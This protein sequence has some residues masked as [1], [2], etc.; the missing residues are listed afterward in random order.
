MRIT[1]V[2][3]T[4]RR[5]LVWLTIVAL[6][7]SL[8]AA[9]ASVTAAAPSKPRVD[10]AVLFAADGL[11]QDLVESYAKQGQMPTM[12]SFLRNG[13]KASGN[14]MLTQAPPNTG[15]G[16]YTMATGAWPGVTGSTN[17]TFHISGQPF[18]NRTAAF[19][20]GVLQA[21]SIAQSAERDGLKVAQVEWAGG[22]NAAIAGPT[23]D[24]R[25]FLSG[26]GVATNFIGA[27][28]EPLFDDVPFISAFGLQFDHPAGYAGQAAFPGA[29]PT[30]VSGWTNVPASYSPAMEMRLRVIDFGTDKYGLNAYIYDSTNNA[31]VDYDRV[32]F[33][34]SKDGAQKVGDLKKGQWADVK[35]KVQGGA[36]D[37]LTAGFLVKVEELTRD[38][39]RVRLFH[40]SVTRANASWPGFPG[41][42]GITDFAEF[43]A[44][45]FPTSTAADFAILEAG[46]TSEETYV[47]Q[48]LYWAKA[49]LP[50]LE[51]VVK[52]YKPDLLLA[53]YPTTD[54]FQHQFLGLITRKLPNGANNPAYDDVELDGIRDGRV[55]A[56]SR[57]IRDAYKGA[58][59]ALT[60]A[61]K[62]MGKD[63]TTF[64][65]SDHGFAPQF[66]AIDA[67]K[68]LVD[69]GLLSKPQTSNCRPATGET[70][71]KAKACWAG[72]TVQIYL[73]LAG[74]DPVVTGLQQVPAAEEAATV[75]TIK[76]AFLALKDPNDWTRD[77]QPEGWKMMDRA[78]T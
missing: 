46:V 1:P 23:I 35:V 58:D 48:G 26:R 65:G 70:I 3:H 43:L 28:G 27:P 34:P 30:P 29:A 52:T 10:R 61:R 5:A 32:L 38:L 37:G 68:V 12:R 15:A 74:R 62:L 41:S 7:A 59:K 51:Y 20:P 13:A 8:A 71:G 39:S 76:A 78:Y 63:P 36:L 21:E 4:H 60:L 16:W 19:D 56:R 24:F 73:N 49:H 22:R 57:F 33:S 14:G 42:A 75:A 9:P 64:V 47:E 66:L 6:L 11:R 54:E 17:N 77:G 18:G 50:M 67:S 25:V 31:K 45:K 55:S 40:T 69:L 72:G 53:G 2:A 44:Q